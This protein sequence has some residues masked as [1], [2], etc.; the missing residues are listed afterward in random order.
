MATRYK[1]LKI[2]LLALISLG[3]IGDHSI[4]PDLLQLMDDNDLKI[5]GAAATA[6]LKIDS[7]EETKK[8]VQEKAEQSNGTRKEEKKV[9]ADKGI[10]KEFYSFKGRFK[11]NITRTKAVKEQLKRPMRWG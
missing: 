7:S 4:I 6:I 5:R 8:L 3:T 2:R 11:R 10:D 9:L 1:T